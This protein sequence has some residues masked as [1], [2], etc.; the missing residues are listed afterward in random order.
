[1]GG[2]RRLFDIAVPRNVAADVNEM[3]ES[4][5]VYNVDDLKEVCSQPCRFFL[6]T[7]TQLQ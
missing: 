2:V 3:G 4:A 6:L 7:A 1:M 5:H